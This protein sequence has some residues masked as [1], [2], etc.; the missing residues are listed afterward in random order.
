[1]PDKWSRKVAYDS[2]MATLAL[3]QL[4]DIANRIVGMDCVFW[5]QAELLAQDDNWLQPNQP[6]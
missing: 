6:N 5:D 2:T 1:M 3:A 4:E